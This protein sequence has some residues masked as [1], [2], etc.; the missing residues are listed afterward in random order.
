MGEG[1][2]DWLRN[3]PSER[4]PAR[5]EV[6]ADSHYETDFDRIVGAIEDIIIEDGFQ[7]LQNNMLEKYFH[8]F[9]NSEEN[10]LIYTDIYN[11]YTTQ[12]EKHIEAEL[13][14]KIPD[15]KMDEFLAQL[16]DMHEELEGDVF[17]MLFTLSDFLAFKDLFV[18]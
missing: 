14:Q 10:K 17:E 1:H 5:E 11:E 15:F 13:V 8:H 3:E 4:F 16:K 18:D 12:I 6:F 7:D 2:Q 9:D